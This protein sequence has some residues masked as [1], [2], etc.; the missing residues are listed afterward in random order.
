MNWSD[1]GLVL[2]TRILGESSV[3]LEAMTRERGRH[4][5]L[6]RGGRSRRLRPVLQAG[7]TV[8]L[9]W[10]ARLDEQ[11]GTYGLEEERL[12]AARLMASPLALYG[13]STLVG[14]LRLFAER[15]PHP[16]IFDAAELLVEN[17]DDPA[18]ARW[19]FARFELMLL[20]ELGFGLD[21]T[22]CAATGRRDDLA[23]V[24]PR[25]GRAVSR[26]AGAPY[27]DRLLP[28]PDF[29]HLPD[30]LSSGDNTVPPGTAEVGLAFALTGHFLGAHI[31]GPRGVPVPGERSRFVAMALGGPAAPEAGTVS[32]Q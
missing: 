12:R 19:L 2:G 21:L 11:L 8:L 18:S 25:T 10:R 17:L 31:Y 28:L 29:L 5:G 13:A 1:R 26:E 20:A 24:S 23:Y 14:H 15:D 22:Q 3:V 30:A 4:F 9:T 16:G 27:R 6:V 32:R 7:N